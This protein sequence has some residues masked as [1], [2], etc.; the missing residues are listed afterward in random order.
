MKFRINFILCS[1][2]S[3]FF[4]HTSYADFINGNFEATYTPDL[5]TFSPITGWTQTG[6][7]FTG[8]GP[9]PPAAPTSISSINLVTT[10]A[11][12]I[13]EHV[14]G[15]GFLPKSTDDY[16]LEGATPTPTLLLP[17][18]GTQSLIIN[19][20]PYHTPKTKSG[21]NLSISGWTTVASRATEVSQTITVSSTDVDA[22]DHKVHIRFIAAPVL[23]NSPHAA[24]QQPFVAI[25]LDNST[26]GRT[27]ANPLYFQWN[28]GGQP[29]AQWNSLTAGGTNQGSD[30]SYQYQIFNAFD[31]SPGNAFIHVGDQITLRLLAS[32]CSPGGHE[33]HMYVDQVGVNIPSDLLWISGTGPAQSTPGNNITYTYT[34]TNTENVPVNNVEIVVGMPV[35]ANGTLQKTTFVSVTTPT[36]GTS[37]PS[38]TGTLGQTTP[39]TCT[40]GTLSAGQTGTFQ[41]TVNIPSGW[42]TSTGPVNHGNYTIGTTGNPELIGPLIQTGLVAPSSSSNLSVNVSGLPTTATDG[43]AYSGS[44]TCSNTTDA[45]ASGNATD[46]TCDIS[47]LPPG[48][49]STG[50]VIATTSPPPPSSPVWTDHS[51]I[52]ANQIVTC[53]VS[54]T[55]TTPGTFIA[56]AETSATNNSNTTD[57]TANATIIVDANVTTS[58]DGH[59][60]ITPPSRTVTSGST[61]SFTVTPDTGYTLNNTHGGTCPAGSF[62][63]NTYTTGAI[64]NN[65]NVTF[66]ATIN[67]YQ[68]TPS[69]DGHETFTP[70]TPQTVNYNLTQAFT[71]TADPGYILLQT[72]GGTCPTGSFSGNT[73]TTGQIIA[74]CTVNFSVESIIPATINGSTVLSPVSIC[75]GRPVLLGDLPGGTGPT[76]YTATPSSNDIQC[77]IGHSGSQAYLKVH[78]IGTCT[79]T[80]TRTGAPSGSLTVISHP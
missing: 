49:T 37:S 9:T 56:S 13:S 7:T 12:A 69:G 61:A 30:S 57:N 46:A 15:P 8:A 16:F 80:G 6:Y 4:F 54:G 29:G 62:S 77:I 25:E 41:M 14:G 39:I 74:D 51:T 53:D 67:T 28:Y 40:I 60:T 1:L 48:L 19:V 47:N 18:A 31:I 44:F 10:P 79:V 64:T 78:G 63:G 59:E 66:S 55:P 65:C 26:T 75:C 35:Q 5:T 68:V 71:V 50:C 52:P 2:L 45:F 70:N 17:I 42:A 11:S 76:T 27:G 23:Q 34:Y 73:Y 72:T 38:C 3:L 33:G 22:T 21:T 43:F 20:R 36:A 24:N 58:G 32:G